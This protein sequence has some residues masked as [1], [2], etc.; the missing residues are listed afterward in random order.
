MTLFIFCQNFQTNFRQ[1]FL[2]S[3]LSE[4]LEI[5]TQCLLRHAIS[6]DIFLYQSDAN[7]L[8]NDDFAYF[9]TKIFKQIFVKEFSATVY[10]RCLK[11]LHSIC[12]GMLYRGMYFCTNRTSTSCLMSSLFIFSQNFQTNFRQRFLSKCLS[13]MLEIFT[14]CLLRP[15]IS[16]DIFLYQSDVNF[17]LNDDFVY[18]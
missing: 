1:R 18:F 3:Y 4:M 11:F 10:C 9:L 5:F 16:W 2:C 8:L 12:I 6:W 17:L 15:V 13:Q 14:Q 7:F